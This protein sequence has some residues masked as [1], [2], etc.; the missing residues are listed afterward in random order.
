MLEIEFFRNITISHTHIEIFY[1]KI[2]YQSEYP[3]EGSAETISGNPDCYRM[4]A[5]L[6]SY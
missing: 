4:R 6:K 3:P 1:P 2:A 5:R